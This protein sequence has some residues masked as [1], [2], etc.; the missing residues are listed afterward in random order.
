MLL[1]LGLPNL[2]VIRKKL[3]IANNNNNGFKHGRAT[4]ALRVKEK[5][6]LR[7]V[8][9]STLVF[10]PCYYLLSKKEHKKKKQGKVLGGS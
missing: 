4:H 5:T 1:L 2:L 8:F 3:A 7:M 6:T 9:S 10:S